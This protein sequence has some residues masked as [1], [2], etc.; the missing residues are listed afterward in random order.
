MPRKSPANPDR[1]PAWVN[2]LAVC[3]GIVLLLLILGDFWGASRSIY[4]PKPF[5]EATL[6]GA[7]RWVYAS[8]LPLD[9]EVALPPQFAGASITGKAY[10]KDG[11]IFFPSWV[12]RK[13]RLP[14]YE[15]GDWLE[16]YGFSAQSLPT[17][18][19]S[20]AGSDRFF[21]M[22]DFNAA[23]DTAHAGREQ[24]Q[25]AVQSLITKHWYRIDSFS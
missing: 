8:K 20:P 19:D 3:L 21:I 2:R 22:L 18:A 24:R 6:T 23:R 14:S 1:V 7:V 5:N 25:M 15:D 4:R 12:G 17:L 13:T 9:G 10:V 16:G 11:V